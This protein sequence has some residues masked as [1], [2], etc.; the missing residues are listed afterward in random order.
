MAQQMLG[1]PEGWLA[2]FDGDEELNPNNIPD[3][4]NEEQ[5][6][7][8]AVYYTVAELGGAAQ[9]RAD[10][11]FVGAQPANAQGDP[12]QHLL[13]AQ[14]L[15]R[16]VDR[17]DK[18]EGE[19]KDITQKDA[20]SILE[21]VPSV[22]PD[23]VV[24]VGAPLLAWFEELT[25]TYLT[26][27]YWT[28]QFAF[29]STSKLFRDAPAF[30]ATWKQYV[31]SNEKVKAYRL[32]GEW[33]E[34]WL[35]VAKGIVSSH[36]GDLHA[37]LRKAVKPSQSNLLQYGERTVN[38]V[39]TAH[40]QEHQARTVL[41]LH[42]GVASLLRILQE[43]A[44]NLTY[45]GQ[46][47]MLGL[48]LTE[49]EGQ[50]IHAQVLAVV[51]AHVD[52]ERMFSFYGSLSPE[53]QTFIEDELQQSDRHLLLPTM[54]A[55][56]DEV[57]TIDQV[58]TLAVLHET[59]SKNR[60]T[61][62][63][64][65]IKALGIEVPN[66]PKNSRRKP[67]AAARWA[68][69]KGG[70][71]QGKGGK[72]R[73][74]K[75]KGKDGKGKGGK[76]RS[77]NRWRNSPEDEVP[78]DRSDCTAGLDGEINAHIQCCG[79]HLYGHVKKKQGVWN[80]PSCDDDWGAGAG[81]AAPTAPKAVV[82]QVGGSWEWTAATAPAPAPEA[83]VEQ[84][85]TVPM[86]IDVDAMFDAMACLDGQEDDGAAAE[87][88]RVYLQKA[89]ENTATT[90]MIRLVPRP[91]ARCS[92]SDQIHR[93]RSGTT[94]ASSARAPCV[95][96]I[97]KGLSPAGQNFRVQLSQGARRGADFETVDDDGGCGQYWFTVE[98][99]VEEV[100]VYQRKRLVRRGGGAATLEDKRGEILRVVTVEICKVLKRAVHVVLEGVLV[101]R[102]K[103]LR[104]GVFDALLLPRAWR[105]ASF[106]HVIR[107]WDAHVSVEPARS[108]QEHWPLPQVPLSHDGGLVTR[109]LQLVGHSGF[110]QGKTGS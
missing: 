27:Q 16:M 109:L 28:S 69:G 2:E 39:A 17:D 73:D 40:L 23:G 7:R 60:A 37:A 29:N 56:V 13:M 96:Q 47:T 87:M 43:D 18:R 100:V 55:S 66:D 70:E 106:L 68:A 64:K 45:N 104:V 52:R 54:F 57:A 44:D 32:K 65:A 58:R 48:D 80:C 1:L 4:E 22:A 41:N 15:Q 94:A 101:V 86:V 5:A 19:R 25:T 59:R 34:A 51:Q 99:K 9:P 31:Q 78:V 62:L 67:T 74:G 6:D 95:V 110:V 72:G 83:V 75:G 76:G 84:I 12:G 53:I 103:D 24:L 97:V 91:D 10:A 71:G 93:V 82:D 89:E 33:K 79:C 46:L 8:L 11:P 42:D 61:D 50:Q 36:N 63:A 35:V 77:R 108:R 81:G 3:P 85:A 105:S 49:Y 30:E 102:R 14:V 38:D 90:R 26:D 98:D 21:A 107:I 88:R 92:V 20:T